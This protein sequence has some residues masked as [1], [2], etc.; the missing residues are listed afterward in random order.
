MRNIGCLGGTFDPIHK[1][2][3]HLAK[4]VYDTCKL[5]EVK[6]I[7]C[8]QAVHRDSVVATPEQRLHMAELACADSPY[9]TCDN[10]EFRLSGPSYSINSIQALKIQ[11]PD[12]HL[13]FIIGFD[14]FAQFH[15]WKGWQEILN[16]CN[17]I[18]ARRPNSSF[19]NSDTLRLL[20]ERQVDHTELNT[21]AFGKIA[22]CDFNALNLSSTEIRE[23]IKKNLDV[24]RNLPNTVYNF[25]VDE[26]IY[27]H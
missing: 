5:D 15:T 8:Y 4:T 25:I 18:V 14:V 21:F 3:L 27:A 7:P 12:D 11:Y 20:S 10:I 26:E 17:L 16:L 22:L 13:H 6:L 1:G 2:H 9:L 19:E 23:N 24:S